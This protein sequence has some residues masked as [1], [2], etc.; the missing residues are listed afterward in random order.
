[1]TK[2]PATDRVHHPVRGFAEDGKKYHARQ[3]DGGAAG[4]LAVHHE[5]SDPAA[6]SQQLRSNDKHSRPAQSAA[7]P[8]DVLGQDSRKN[9]SAHHLEAAQPV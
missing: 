4:H 3:D 1:M 6:R 7:K 2:K 9:E 5:I 8:D